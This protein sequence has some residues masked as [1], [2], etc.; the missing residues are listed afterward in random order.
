[1][2]HDYRADFGRLFNQSKYSFTSDQ[3][4]FNA[5]DI[6]VVARA[7]S[8]DKHTAEIQEL[9]EKYEKE[10]ERL[11]SATDP[12]YMASIDNLRGE[13]EKLRALLKIANEKLGIKND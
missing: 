1:M 3:D 13:I 7:T 9:R 12:Y 11:K 8:R 4:Y 2:G 6:Y 5:E 10:L